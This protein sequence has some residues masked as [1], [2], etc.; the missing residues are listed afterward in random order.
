MVS[1]GILLQPH[2]YIFII[3]EF[4]KTPKSRGI[5]FAFYLDSTVVKRLAS[6]KEG[7]WFEPSG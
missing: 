3:D 2:I 4:V 6:H 5:L 1:S 7:F